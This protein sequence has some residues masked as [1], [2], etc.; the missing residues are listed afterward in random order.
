MR[1]WLDTEFIEEGKTI[2]L[3]SIGIVAEDGRELYLQSV[4]FDPSKASEW[5]QENVFPH[6]SV[7]PHASVTIDSRRPYAQD[8]HY[9]RNRGQ[10]TFSNPDKRIIGAHTDCSWRNRNQMVHEIFTF[11]NVKAYGEPEIWGWCS[12]YDFVVLCQIYGTMMDLPA[13]FP[14]YMR[15]IQSLLDDHGIPDSALP[16]VEGAAHNALIDAKQIKVIWDYLKMLETGRS[17]FVGDI[18]IDPSSGLHFIPY[19]VTG[20][21][22]ISNDHI[23]ITKNELHTMVRDMIGEEMRKLP[24]QIRRQLGRVQE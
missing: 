17:H 8:L 14:H 2:D 4:E 10:C 1:Y 21:F 16:L 24:A 5:V 9:H 12:G 20:G 23:T 13:G 6:L 19:S 3:V 7:C 22:T 11:M 18:S 15:D